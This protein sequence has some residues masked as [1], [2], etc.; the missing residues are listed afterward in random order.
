[1]LKPT[2][3]APAA[4]HLEYARN[5]LI[6]AAREV[7]GALARARAGEAVGDLFPVVA[8]TGEANNAVHSARRSVKREAHA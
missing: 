1:M 2:G 7:G 3:A 8:M 6:L 5:Q 4:A